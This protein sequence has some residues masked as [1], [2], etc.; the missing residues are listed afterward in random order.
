VSRRGLSHTEALRM[1]ER[2]RRKDFGH[3]EIE[4]TVIDPGAYAKP[5]SYTVEKTLAADTEML[6]LVCE[7]SSDHWSSRTT[8]STVHVPPEVLTRYVGA[9]SGIYQGNPR[10]ARF[11]ISNGQLFVS[12]GGGD[13][14]PLV[15]RSE[16]LFEGT[17]GY[18]FEVDARGVATH[19]T[20]IHVSGGYRYTRQP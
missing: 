18:Q 1:V 8:E 12:S 13:A 16:T 6:E 2:Y 10:T 3:L 15:P 5:W 9:Y 7:R 17:L 20:E 4:V 19:V 14:Q 11:S